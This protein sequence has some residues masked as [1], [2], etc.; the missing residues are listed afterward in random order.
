MIWK[1][2]EHFRLTD[3]RRKFGVNLFLTIFTIE[4]INIQ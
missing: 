1:T 2:E 4:K 3:R